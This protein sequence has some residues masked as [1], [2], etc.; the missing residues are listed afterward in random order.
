MPLLKLEMMKNNIIKQYSRL[1][2]IGIVTSFAM[3]SCEEDEVFTGSP[4]PSNV[5]FIALRGSITT[6]ETDVVSAQSFPIT[7]SLG[8]NP[9]TSEADLLT[10]PVDVNVEVVSFLPNLNK[11]LR[12]TFVIPA[13]ENSL[14]SNMVVPSGDATTDFLQ[15]ESDVQ[16]F[17]SAITTSPNDDNTRGFEGKLYSIASDTINLNYSDTPLT[18][19]NS[20]RLGIRFDYKGPWPT[21][22]TNVND[23]SIVLK[24]NGAIMPS[25]S[26][27][28]GVSSGTTRPITGTLNQADRY[29][30]INFLDAKQDVKIL[31]ATP[32]D[33]INNI[34][35]VKSQRGTSAGTDKPHNFKVG[36]EVTVENFDGTGSAPIV[37]QV[38]TVVDA[39]TWTFVYAGPHLFGTNP[40]FY[41]PTFIDKG[42]WGPFL[43][44]VRNDKVLF[45]GTTYYAKENIPA[46]LINNGNAYP[47]DDT[48]RWTS[49]PPQFDWTVELAA[50]HPTWQ[51]RAAYATNTIVTYNGLKYVAKTDIA[52]RPTPQPVNLNPETDTDRWALGA[53]E[54]TVDAQTYTSTDTYTIEVYARTLGGSTSATVAEMPYRFAIRFPDE[55]SKVYSGILTNL[56]T[57]PASTAIPKLQIV[58]TT[59]LGV[60]SYVVTP[61]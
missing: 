61:L 55:S 23:L 32:A 4:D 49:T 30:T 54:Y 57:G 6:A 52:A 60:S 7:V 2:L 34:Y 28:Q 35:T 44:Y 39:Y 33:R 38:A 51:N 45:N 19:V 27:A 21:L 13:G 46:V 5:N 9:E 36:D 15:F 43:S 14:T 29:E 42:F 53:S 31:N 10:F 48:A 22:G 17:L 8:D 56:S 37:F 59:A 40:S 11:R 12:R 18:G 58:K 16:L 24:K 3:M 20:K 25:Q 41:Q 47:V 26:T 1:I 50:T